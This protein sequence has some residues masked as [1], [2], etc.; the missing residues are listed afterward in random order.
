MIGDNSHTLENYLKA[1]YKLSEK[2]SGT[3]TT[4]EIAAA[5][6]TRPS[7]AN[8]MIRK[9]SA[10]KYTRHQKYKGV[11]ITDKGVKAALK[12]IRKHRLWEL[13]LVKVLNFR[14]DE[15]HIIAEQLE[16]VASDEL[17]N[18]LDQF[19]GFP[20]FDPHGDPIPDHNGKIQKV[21]LKALSE[22][23]IGEGG[24]IN[25][26]VD[27]SEQFLRYLE[28]FSLNIGNKVT[29]VDIIAYDRSLQL[30]IKNNQMIQVSSNVADNLLIKIS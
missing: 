9:L 1:V 25:G 10:K 16:H 7:S 23:K 30:K 6:N 27:H 20:K 17:I 14:W 13:F 11:V 3:V 22:L 4:N 29:V 2:S 19:L 28:K 15:V 8:D 5:L 21:P 26:V 12:V 18:R 24:I